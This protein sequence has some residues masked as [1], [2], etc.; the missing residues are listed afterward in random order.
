MA[1]LSLH[2]KRQRTTNV[3]KFG[4]TSLQDAHHI[5]QVIKTIKTQVRAGDYVVVS[6]NGKVTDFLL[7]FI[8][9]QKNAL[10]RLL[11][12][13]NSLIESTLDDSESL[14]K[15]INQDLNKISEISKRSRFN[16]HKILAFGELWSAQLLS[17]KLNRKSD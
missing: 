17:A 10:V 12:Y 4:G 8:Q 11:G 5:D 6:A 3:H 1:D 13:L 14:L 16:Y 2:H 7:A 15:T 9:G